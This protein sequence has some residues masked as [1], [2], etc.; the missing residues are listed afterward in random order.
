MASG[1]T[2]VT[3]PPAAFS[4][5]G[6]PALS[7]LALA[8]FIIGAAELFLLLVVRIVASVASQAK[9]GA[10]TL[11]LTLGIFGLV[12]LLPTVAAIVL[13]HIAVVQT[14]RGRRRGVGVAF[15]GLGLGYI[16]L[17]FWGNRVLVAIIAATYA[18]G[19]AQFVPNVF[20]WA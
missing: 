18:G 9:D 11:A 19:V 7:G 14:V 16:N 5:V 17:L 12:S 13:G 1:A 3:A 10:P 20:W 4:P 8:S 2:H 6:R 15:L